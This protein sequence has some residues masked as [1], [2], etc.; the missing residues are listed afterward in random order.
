MAT[1]GEKSTQPVAQ[2][3]EK[4]KDSPAS[5]ETSLPVRPSNSV[6]T[7][8]APNASE[9]KLATLK[10]EPEK[11]LRKPPSEKPSEKPVEK[12]VEKPAEKPVEKPAEKPAE[13]PVSSTQN[14]VHSSPS[15][16]ETK[17]K[18]GEPSRIGYYH[19]L[20]YTSLFS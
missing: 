12:P 19:I 15:T 4:S 2:S 14:D 10:Q 7:S 11:Q 18:P 8:D 17:S 16:K 6:A 5:T 13:K 1:P 3:E 9:A 20:D